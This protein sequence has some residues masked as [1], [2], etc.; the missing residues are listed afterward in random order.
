MRLARR[1]QERPETPGQKLPEEERRQER[2][3]TRKEQIVRIKL[4]I[5]IKSC[6][7]F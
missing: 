7:N 5:S 6:I 2:P 3:R 4:M 1:R